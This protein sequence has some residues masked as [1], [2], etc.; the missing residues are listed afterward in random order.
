MVMV[1]QSYSRA[2]SLIS[3]FISS[4][5]SVL[6]AVDEAD[7]YTAVGVEL[8]HLLKYVVSTIVRK[9]PYMTLNQ[10]TGILI[11]FSALRP[12]VFCHTIVH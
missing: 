9:Q 3:L 1:I 2:L 7:A 4:L 8:L 12:C 11:S 6:S 10:R 5:L